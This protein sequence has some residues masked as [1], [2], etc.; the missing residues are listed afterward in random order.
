MNVQGKRGPCEGEMCTYLDDTQAAFHH[1]SLQ[2][3]TEG[4]RSLLGLAL[5]H[6]QREVKISRGSTIANE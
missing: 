4:H 2:P 1:T 3:G 6:P 5:S